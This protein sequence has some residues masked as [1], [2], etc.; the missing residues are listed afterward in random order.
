MATTGE[1]TVQVAVSW[2]GSGD[3]DGAYDD[4]TNDVAIDPGIT[5]DE[6]RDGSRALAPPKV[7]AIDFELHNQERTYSQE[8]SGSPIYQ[9]VLAGRPVRVSALLDESTEYR[10]ADLYRAH[11]YYR[12]RATYRLATGRI[13]DISQTT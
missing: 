8:Y 5:I 2:D 4:V 10:E 6:G 1:I 9:R 13:D 11:D 7:N 3:F 12:G